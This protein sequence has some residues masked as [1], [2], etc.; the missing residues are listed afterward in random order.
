MTIATL[1][2]DG[3]TSQSRCRTCCDVTEVT[4]RRQ[5]HG[6]RASLRCHG[7]HQ[8]WNGLR[9]KFTRRRSGKIITQSPVVNRNNM[10]TDCNKS[11]VFL[12]SA[13]ISDAP[14][15]AIYLHR[16]DK[17]SPGDKLM[18]PAQCVKKYITYTRS[19]AVRYLWIAYARRRPVVR[20][21]S[22]GENLRTNIDR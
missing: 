21:F 19:L 4:W 20:W 3:I 11:V 16:G 14:M 22:S 13:A 6:V 1:A 5:Q 17:L 12:A 9:H 15:S 10:Y 8:S 7:D 2:V 18:T